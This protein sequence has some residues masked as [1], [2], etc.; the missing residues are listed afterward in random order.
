MNNKHSDVEVTSTTVNA[1][2]RKL[3]ASWT[4]EN[5]QGGSFFKRE[6]KPLDS[7]CVPKKFA[8][9]VS[10]FDFDVN[11]GADLLK[12]ISEN[13]SREDYEIDIEDFSME[14]YFKNSRDVTFFL[15]KWS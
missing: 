3:K 5:V 12:W 7:E 6:I 11:R 1:R 10:V 8:G 14:I 9:G 13:Y 2:P 4:I 15:L